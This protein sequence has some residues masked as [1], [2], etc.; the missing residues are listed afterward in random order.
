MEAQAACPL[1]ALRVLQAQMS[2][3]SVRKAAE[4]Q[5]FVKGLHAPADEYARRLAACGSCPSHKA[6]MLCAECGSYTAYRARLLSAT[7]P[8]PAGSRW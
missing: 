7:C 3:E 2:A 6:D 1:C 4:S 5:P 8:F